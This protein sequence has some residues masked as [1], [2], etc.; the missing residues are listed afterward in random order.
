MIARIAVAD[1]DTAIVTGF[2]W[3]CPNLERQV[4]TT[5]DIGFVLRGN[6]IG[7]T[8]LDR[9]GIRV[10][11]AQVPLE[12]EYLTGFRIQRLR[13]VNYV[14]WQLGERA[15]PG[16][17]VLVGDNGSGKTSIL[18]GLALALIGSDSAQALRQDWNTWLRSGDAT[19]EIEVTFQRLPGSH[20]PGPLPV[21][22]SVTLVLER[23][24]DGATLRS[25]PDDMSNLLS[26]GYGPFRRFSGRDPE[27]EKQLGVFPRLARHISLFDD[28]VG[29]T[30]SL[31]W[32]RDLQFK[33]L[34]SDQEASL[35]LERV[36]KLVNECGLLP[37]GVRLEQISS[38]AVKFR[39][40]LGHE[41][42]IEEL[43][44]GYRSI[45]SMTFD[46]VRQLATR[47][48]ASRVFDH[49]KPHIV[50]APAIVLIDEIDAHL[51]PAWQRTVGQWFRNH[52]PQVQFI[53]T[54]H[55]PLVCQA[56]QSGSIFRLPDPS[57]EFDAGEML[58]GPALSRLVY[59]DVLEAYGSGAFGDGITRSE[60]AKTLLLQLA[61]LNRKELTVELSQEEA[62]EQEKLRAALP[63][64]ATGSLTASAS[65]SAPGTSTATDP[66]RAGSA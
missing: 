22:R 7:S 19:A 36:T 9:V 10:H 54:T 64:T 6:G 14:D 59:G 45:L 49:E 23:T 17:H 56:A 53:V 34:E 55:S 65:C 20:I 31:T 32:L 5:T 26:A 28:R 47:F 38:D 3:L 27:D 58:E 43:S 50:T 39:D 1:D 12:A 40:E 46:I 48:G 37:A 2:D 30:E 24:A 15:A 8:L 63:L 11:E 4:T 62:T 25:S 21:S 44:D 66:W 57:D 51:H 18:R 41:Y 61:E 52:F 42:G 33:R 16:W 35:L 29:L 60:T 13:S